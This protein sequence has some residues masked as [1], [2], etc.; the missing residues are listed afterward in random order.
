M[1][2]NWANIAN[3]TRKPTRFAPS[4]VR[5]RKNVKS[6]IGAL[7]RRSIWTNAASPTMATANNPMIRVEPQCQALPCT[8][9]STSAVSPIVSAPMPR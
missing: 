4:E 5:E 8:R 2:K 7:T 3:V 1:K 9:A 6:I